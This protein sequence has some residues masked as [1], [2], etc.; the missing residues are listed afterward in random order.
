[1]KDKFKATN[2]YKPGTKEYYKDALWIIWALCVD[3]DGFR[4]VKG[5]KSLIDD[6]KDTASRAR[7]HKKMYYELVKNKNKY[8]QVQ[9]P[10]SKMWNKINVETAK[11]VS[12][13]KTPYKNIVKK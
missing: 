2:I 10:K 9:N 8:V 6:I 5:L 3:Y 1:M 7:N 12:S 4:T 13:K 11:I